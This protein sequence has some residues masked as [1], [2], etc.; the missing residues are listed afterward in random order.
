MST[1][2]AEPTIVYIAG[3]GRSGSTLLD[4]LLNAHPYIFGAGEL[5]EIFEAAAART[6]CSCGQPLDACAIWSYVLNH[7]PAHTT[8]AEAEHLTRR[9]ETPRWLGGSPRNDEAY[10]LLWRTIFQAIAH[11]TGA[12]MV[13]D[14][15][16]NSRN[17][18]ER[19]AALIRTTH[20]PVRIIHLVRDPRAILYATFRGSNRR[21]EAEGHAPTRRTAMLR[22]LIGWM[23]AHAAVE[24]TRA[25][26]PHIPV[27]RIRYEDLTGTPALTL[28]QIGGFLNIDMQPVINRLH[29]GAP[30]EGG[31]GI[32][33]NRMRRAGAVHIRADR[34]WEQ[35]LPRYAHLLAWATWPLAHRYAYDLAHPNSAPQGAST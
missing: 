21:L 3:Y 2:T 4:I 31:H 11:Q 5:T 32:G 27:K 29:T 23:M 35:A 12:R 33:G 26:Y 18:A 13:L 30:F 17:T 34:A 1:Y 19:T 10:G 9:T 28:Q 25:A 6:P 20:L 22:V 24:R 14:S 15:S 7:L 8:P 16:K